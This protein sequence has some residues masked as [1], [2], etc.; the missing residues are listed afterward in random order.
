MVERIVLVK[1]SSGSERAAIAERIHEA[2]RELPELATLSVGLP[3]DPASEKSWD[4]SLIL[5]FETLAALEQALASESFRA[6]FERE[7]A[8]VCQV[9]KAWSFA[10]L[11][12]QK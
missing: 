1:L 5:R 10:P 8:P 9:V 7:L 2:L 3:A 11:Q 4:V 6:L 12:T